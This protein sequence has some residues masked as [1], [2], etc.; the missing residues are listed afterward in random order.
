MPLYSSKIFKAQIT[1]N[2][3]FLTG[4]TGNR[5]FGCRFT[6]RKKGK[7][8]QNH[9]FSLKTNVIQSILNSF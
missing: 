1:K 7:S 8:C 9:S 6:S 2:Q 3:A 4:Q 5:L